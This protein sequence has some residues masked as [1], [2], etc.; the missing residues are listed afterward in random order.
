MSENENEISV[1]EITEWKER[2][3]EGWPLSH[4]EIFRL[5]NFVE[6]FAHWFEGNISMLNPKDEAFR[7][8]L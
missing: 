6:V 5:L 7:G 3:S 4:E 8:M 1:A 2:Y